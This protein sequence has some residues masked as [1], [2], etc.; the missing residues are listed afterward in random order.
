MLSDKHL[1]R[2]VH[3]QS[4]VQGLLHPVGSV[5]SIS[6]AVGRGTALWKTSLSVVCLNPP[7]EASNA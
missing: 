5:W 6:Q 7:G 3:F 2:A 4:N 1:G